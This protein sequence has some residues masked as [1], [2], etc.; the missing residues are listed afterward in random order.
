MCI[1]IHGLHYLHFSP[2]FFSDGNIIIMNPYGPRIS[3]G[4]EAQSQRT[5]SWPIASEMLPVAVCWRRATP[6]HWGQKHDSWDESEGGNFCDP[7]GRFCLGR[8]G[9][10]TKIGDLEN[11][12]WSGRGGRDWGGWKWGRCVWWKVIHIRHRRGG[13]EWEVPKDSAYDLRRDSCR[14]FCG[15]SQRNITDWLIDFMWSI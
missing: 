1:C 8:R 12:G 13:K 4:T 6:G 7:E 3:M 2:H 11:S 5:K 10:W 9:S 15:Q 14:K